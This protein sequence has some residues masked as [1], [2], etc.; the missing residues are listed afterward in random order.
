MSLPLV[1]NQ[2]KPNLAAS[3]PQTLQA[4]AIVSQIRSFGNL[5]SKTLHY[6][7][8]NVTEAHLVSDNLVGEEK[9]KHVKKS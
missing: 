6:R 5:F 2:I 1:E 8:Q 7:F 4:R 3:K 9:E